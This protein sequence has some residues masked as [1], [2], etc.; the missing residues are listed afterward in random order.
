VRLALVLPYSFIL[1]HHQHP[2]T[3]TITLTIITTTIIQ[4]KSIQLHQLQ[5]DYSPIAAAVGSNTSI[6]SDPISNNR[7]T[8]HRVQYRGGQATGIQ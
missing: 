8:Q 5:T 2:T 7:R 1:H 3:T 6:N 4:Y